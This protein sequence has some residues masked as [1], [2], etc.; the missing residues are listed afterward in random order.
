MK[1]VMGEAVSKEN[2][3]DEIIT[4]VNPAKPTM[5]TISFNMDP[6]LYI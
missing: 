3:D 1:P 4:I 5:I 2:D 6:I